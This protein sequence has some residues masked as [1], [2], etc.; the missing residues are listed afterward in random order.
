LARLPHMAAGTATDAGQLRQALFHELQGLVTARYGRQLAPVV[1]VQ[2]E[3][4]RQRLAAF[5]KLQAARNQEG[6]Q[7][8]AT[9]VDVGRERAV[10]LTIPGQEPMPLVGRIDRIDYHPA[11]GCYALWDYKTSDQP[12]TPWSAHWSRAKGW[13]QVQLPLYQWMAPA[14]GLSGEI[15]TGYIALPRAVDKV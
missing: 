8:W 6:W 10:L 12:V 1:A 13:S 3:Q 11:T 5:A 4:A 9:E 2:V 15:T 7:I 14:L